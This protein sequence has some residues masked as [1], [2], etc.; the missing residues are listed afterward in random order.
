MRAIISFLSGMNIGKFLM[1]MVLLLLARLL[2][3]KETF[4]IL[5]VLIFIDLITGI[6]KNIRTKINL[7]TS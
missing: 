1:G 3:T 5:F 4:V 7:A 6:R 2:E